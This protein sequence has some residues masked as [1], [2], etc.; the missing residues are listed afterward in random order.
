MKTIARFL[1]N[2]QSK[3]SSKE[4]T[5]DNVAE[6]VAAFL[7][8]N[9]I[10]SV[11]ATNYITT[12]N[13]RVVMNFDCANNDFSRA[14]GLLTLISSLEC[15]NTFFLAFREKGIQLACTQIFDKV[16]ERLNKNYQITV[17]CED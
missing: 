14:I 17:E 6:A 16:I 11:C 15:N 10:D 5:I 12:H 2:N 7:V 1:T 4:T 3:Q 8:R 13:N 9:G